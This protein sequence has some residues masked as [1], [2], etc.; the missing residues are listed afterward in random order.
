MGDALETF[1]EGLHQL[2]LDTNGLQGQSSPPLPRVPARGESPPGF[3][4][5]TIYEGR[6]PGVYGR[7][8]SCGYP[9]EGWSPHMFDKLVEQFLRY[10]QELLDW[11][12]RINLT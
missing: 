9:G 2:G 3:P 1:V 5:P 8:T 12:T 11:N 6:E 7:G 10:R 4:A